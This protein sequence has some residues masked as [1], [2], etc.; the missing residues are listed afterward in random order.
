MHLQL[1]LIALAFRY[2]FTSVLSSPTNGIDP[3]PQT[4]LGRFLHK[5]LV[6]PLGPIGQIREETSLEPIRSLFDAGGV[7]SYKGSLK[8]PSR[9]FTYKNGEEFYVE[10]PAA[11]KISAG[12][13]ARQLR[14]DVSEKGTAT[15][16]ASSHTNIDSKIDLRSYTEEW[17]SKGFVP[18]VM[19]RFGEALRINNKEVYP[20]TGQSFDV[21]KAL[22]SDLGWDVQQVKEKTDNVLEWYRNNKVASIFPEQQHVLDFNLAIAKTDHRPWWT[23]DNMAAWQATNMPWETITQVGSILERQVKPPM[24]A[25]ELDDVRKEILIVLDNFAAHNNIEENTKHNIARSRGAIATA[26]RE[27][28]EANKAFE[29]KTAYP[30]FD[31]K[32]KLIGPQPNEVSEIKNFLRNQEGQE[33]YVNQNLRVLVHMQLLLNGIPYDIADNYAKAYMIVGPAYLGL[34]T[35]GMDMLTAMK[36]ILPATQ[37]GKIVHMTTYTAL[38]SFFS[39]IYGPRRVAFVSKKA[40]AFLHSNEKMTTSR[41]AWAPALGL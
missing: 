13:E 37:G 23:E 32:L 9:T 7:V 40:S 26:L 39:N 10:T 16:E 11:E 33:L 41:I 17:I 4:H 36:H 14:E 22:P 1:A 3:S 27:A 28:T 30:N 8:R 15:A 18:E 25:E 2:S 34:L 38:R 21:L 31:E 24:S 12:T 20:L 29:S 35:G 6:D 5:R 19:I